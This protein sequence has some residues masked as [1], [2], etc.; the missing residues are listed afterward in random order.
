M[1]NQKQ[2]SHFC[3]T[4]AVVR[5]STATSYST[6]SSVLYHLKLVLLSAKDANNQATLQEPAQES[7]PSTA[8]PNTHE[9]A[10][11]TSAKSRERKMLPELR[12]P[13]CKVSQPHRP[14]RSCF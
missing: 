14:Q 1:D 4:E 3:S 2:E 8:L 7:D 10:K 11:F 13:N 9:E 6:F 12:H 5:S